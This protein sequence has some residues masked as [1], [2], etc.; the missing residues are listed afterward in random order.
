MTVNKATEYACI[1]CQP[2]ADGMVL[3]SPRPGKAGDW[4]NDLEHGSEYYFC[5]ACCQ[6]YIS[7]EAYD[8]HVAS[9]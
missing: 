5:D 3:W 2:D 4:F 9:E 7:R 1:E 8:T 6:E